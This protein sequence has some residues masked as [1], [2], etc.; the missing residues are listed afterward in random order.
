MVENM[1][2][3]AIRTKKFLHYF[4]L[5]SLIFI[6]S[7]ILSIMIG[8]KFSSLPDGTIFLVS[9]Y[10]SLKYGGLDMISI[11]VNNFLI[12]IIFLCFFY[13]AKE[14]RFKRFMG[15]FYFLKMGVI[16]GLVASKAVVVYNLVIALG[17]IVPHGIIEIPTVIAAFAGGWALSDLNDGQ[18]SK[19]P[20]ELIYM[21]IVLFIL[22]AISAYI[23]TY[24]TIDIFNAL[25][26]YYY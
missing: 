2:I 11:F 25:L 16:G 9:H 22:L 18:Q 12:S 7:F 23:E 3:S 26:S 13:Y 4:M 15:M 14:D 21:A 10:T 1:C 20:K 8:L 6:L 5:Y 24:V 19:I 17:M